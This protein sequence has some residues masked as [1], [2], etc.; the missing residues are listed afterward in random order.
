[1]VDHDPKSGEASYQASS[2]DELALV[3]ASKDVGIELTERTK[4]FVEIVESG[5]KKEYRIL[6]EFPFNSDR[7]RMS[8]IIE[9]NGKYSLLCK[10]A[11]SIMADRIKWKPNQ[12]AEV[13]E[14]LEKFAV[15]GLRTLVMSQKDISAAEY[16]DFEQKQT[17]LETSDFKDKD[18]RLF[19]LYSSYERN[20]DYI[21]SSA[22]EDKL[23]RNVPKT[24]AK[25]MSANIR[26]WVLTGDKQETAI[27]IAKS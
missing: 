4:D 24:I 27:E 1:M 23:Q 9:N 25:L 17:E 22:I 3:N 26:I 10:G 5:I 20:L 18:D 6:A 14:H 2:P 16:R 8:V 12:E 7:K 15:E 13:F 19:E 21:G 11:D